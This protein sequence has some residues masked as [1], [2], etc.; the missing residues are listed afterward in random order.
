MDRPVGL[1]AQRKH[2]AD[3]CRSLSL[4]ILFFVN[5]YLFL[6][7]QSKTWLKQSDIGL[8]NTNNGADRPLKIDTGSAATELTGGLTLTGGPLPS[9]AAV[10]TLW[11]CT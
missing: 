9:S 1:S 3:A 11:Y 5:N 6:Y 2:L 4:S 8:I 10:G 7:I